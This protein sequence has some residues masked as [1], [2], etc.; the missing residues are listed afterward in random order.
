M[1]TRNYFQTDSSTFFYDIYQII[2]HKIQKFV[3]DV[4]DTVN[5]E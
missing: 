4:T 5:N 1:G 2:I 3:H